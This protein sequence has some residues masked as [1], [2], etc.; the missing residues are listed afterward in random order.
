[1][2]GGKLTGYRPMARKTLEKA[3]E[4]CGLGLAPALA[5][6]PP[7]PG[8]DF[9]GKLEP[10]E[11]GLVRETGV[12]AACAA[13]MVRLYGTEALGIAR[14]GGEL[15]AGSTALL[16]EVDWAVRAEGAATVEDVLYR[17]IRAPL[18]TPDAREA[19]VEPVAA[20]MA[21]LLGWD[22]DRRRSE[23][24]QTRARLAADLHFV[25]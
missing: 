16:A 20:R 23:I 6:E 13:R 8:G 21:A 18:Y 24:A 19:S 4:V 10:L 14:G 17:R 9:D 15:I 2:A 7:L 12:S 3:A 5:E 22:D 11:E 1:M 25:E